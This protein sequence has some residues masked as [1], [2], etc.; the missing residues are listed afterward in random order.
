[1][2]KFKKRIKS[3]LRGFLRMNSESFVFYESVYKQA[4]ILEKRL[5]KAAAY[6]ADLF[7]RLGTV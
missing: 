2:F 4:A 1:M 6:A 5:G 7:I 3:F